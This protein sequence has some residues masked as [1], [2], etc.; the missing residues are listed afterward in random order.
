[1]QTKRALEFLLAAV[2]FGSGPVYLVGCEEGA[3]E[4]AGEELDQAADEAGDEVEDAL[5]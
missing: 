3:F 5:Q 1:M 4:E 2:V